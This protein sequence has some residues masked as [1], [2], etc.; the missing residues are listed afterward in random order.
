M[1]AWDNETDHRHEERL[2]YVLQL[3]IVGKPTFAHA[4]LQEQPL[5]AERAHDPE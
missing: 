4:Q 2:R 1:S 3:R 5:S